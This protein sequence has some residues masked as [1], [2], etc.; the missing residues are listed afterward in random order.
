MFFKKKNKI[1]FLKFIK[2][3]FLYFS[4]RYLCLEMKRTKAYRIMTANLFLA[5]FLSAMSLSVWHSMK[6]DDSFHCSATKGVHHIHKQHKLP[7]TPEF[8]TTEFI[9]ANLLFVDYQPVESKSI[10]PS[11]HNFF[12]A[13]LWLRHISLRA[14]P[15]I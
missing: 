14:P 15:V 1:L 5:I 9:V 3:Q 7:F 6:P 4:F 2:K 12:Y 11:F 10:V 8:I 13:N